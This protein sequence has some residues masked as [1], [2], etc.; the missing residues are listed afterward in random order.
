[1]AY[2]WVK[3][4]HILSSTVLFGT[5]LG[6][7]F[8]M[9]LAHLRGDIRVIAATARNV[10]IAD[11]LFTAPAVAIQFT[12]GLWLAD[13]MGLALNQFWLLWALILF[14]VVGACWLPVLWLQVRARD[15]AQT[16]ADCNVPLPPAYHRAM[17]W[18]FWLG[19]PAFFAVIGIFWL[20][21]MKP[22]QWG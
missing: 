14:A 6:I 11:T 1:M 16:A 21:V 7:A 20:M 18:W 4:I 15:L 9:R 17:R 2:L 22:S 13:R 19:W 12:T 5:G 3:W 8:F 10:V